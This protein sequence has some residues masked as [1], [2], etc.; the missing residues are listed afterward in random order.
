V[1]AVLLV[2]PDAECGR[3][4]ANLLRREGHRVR[5]ARS[6]RTAL[7]AAA[8]ESFDLAVVDL[9]VPGGGVE[10]AR[11]LARRVRRLYLAVGAPLLPDE[12][13]E[14]AVGF[15]VLRKAAVPGIV[16]DPAVFGPGEPQ[17]A[18]PRR[19]ATRARRRRT[20]ARA[21]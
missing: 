1:R 2:E 8:R 16:A 13:V 11:R 14:A 9:L 7:Q 19:P 12:I 20:R 15:P 3:A 21:S 17:G 6:A 5:L 10:L 18:T 4:T